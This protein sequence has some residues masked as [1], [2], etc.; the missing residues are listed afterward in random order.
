MKCYFQQKNKI[1]TIKLP[2]SIYVLSI[3]ALFILLVNYIPA[4]SDFI[5]IYFQWGFHYF[6]IQQKLKLRQGGRWGKHVITLLVPCQ[7]DRDDTF[8]P[9]AV[10]VGTSSGV[11]PLFLSWWECGG[12]AMEEWSR[13]LWGLYRGWGM[14]WPVQESKDFYSWDWGIKAGRLTHKTVTHLD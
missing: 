6:K 7:G 1:Q 12:N 3:Y 5:I 8:T 2:L 9:G 11:E 14:Q 13:Q 10:T 4:I